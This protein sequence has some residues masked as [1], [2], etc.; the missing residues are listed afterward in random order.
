MT[1]GRVR[2]DTFRPCKYGEMPAAS[3][4]SGVLPAVRLV[5]G[6]EEL[7]VARAVTESIAAAR[8]ADPETEVR[9]YAGGELVAGELAEMLSPSLFGGP[10]LLI[11]RDGQDVFRQDR[12]VRELS[13]RE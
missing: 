10:R 12:H 1:G 13:D 8:A 11:V 5:Q 7:L 3:A 4:S 9:E 2:P 6:D